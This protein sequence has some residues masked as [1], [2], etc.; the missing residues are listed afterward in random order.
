MR[1]RIV[2]FVILAIVTALVGVHLGRSTTTPR[3]VG[4]PATTT[5]QADSPV[6]PTQ[7]RGSGSGPSRTP[8]PSLPKAR[9]PKAPAQ[10]G[11][12]ATQPGHPPAKPPASPSQQRA[13]PVRFGPVT[14]AGRDSDT[15][16]SDDRRALTTM[17]SDFEVA[18]D[19]TLAEP[20]ATKTFT[21]TIPLT[22]GAAGETLWVHAQGYAFFDGGAKGSVTLRG[23]GQQIIQGYATPTDESFLQT[24]L[25]SLELPAR[26]G[27]TYK[28]TFAIDIDQSADHEG[29]GYLNIN[30]IDIEIR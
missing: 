22:D 7:R 24:P 5:T 3:A 2:L 23:G 18:V 27:V 14:T 29:T 13:G 21:M 12:T 16:I 6:G 19:P 8:T 17:L 20:E 1:G 30:P 28:L 11:D 25:Q 10:P 4:E 15:S 9:S 26:P